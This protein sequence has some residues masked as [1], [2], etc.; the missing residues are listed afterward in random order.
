MLLSSL[1]RGVLLK[2]LVNRN[3]DRLIDIR[4][5]A[6]GF[7]D[8]NSRFSVPEIRVLRASVKSLRKKA[9]GADLAARRWLE[10]SSGWLPCVSTDP[11]N[12]SSR[13]PRY[14]EDTV[15]TS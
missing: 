9:G 15:V 3:E 4:Q 11:R 13:D 1:V 12:G 8:D 5:N 10:K 6:T 2:P 14:S 7:G